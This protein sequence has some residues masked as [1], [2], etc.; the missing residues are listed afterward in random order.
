MSE[1]T[2]TD[3]LEVM[4]DAINYNHFLSSLVLK[5]A[6]KSESIV[7]F[8]SGIGTFARELGKR[9]LRVHCI[10]PDAKQAAMIA[11]A[12]MPVSTSLDELPDGSIDYLYT[13]NV[14]EHIED[15][16]AALRQLHNKL[17]PG[18][19]IL[20]YVPAFQVLFSSMDRKVGHFRRYTKQDLTAKLR[21]TQF[22]I[23][24]AKYV[25]SIGFFASL[26]FRFAGN[27]SGTLNHKAL[28]FYDRV[29][30]PIS[31]ICD[32]L[33][34]PFFGKNVVVFAQK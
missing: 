28:V 3:N 22:S 29:I 4:A 34:S 15:D 10:E 31:R 13:L 12:G 19:K 9:G 33:L 17:K 20:I 27:D 23:V 11:A 5:H 25:D 21:D 32:V 30:F 7:D 24:S 16:V 2:G 14:L 8:G 6:Q 18:G 26:Y 1:Y